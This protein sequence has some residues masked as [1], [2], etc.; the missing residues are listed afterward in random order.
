M[1][2]RAVV[3][4]RAFHALAAGRALPVFG[5]FRESDEVLHSDGRL[6]VEQFAA[7]LPHGGIDDSGWAGG[8]RTCGLGRRLLGL[9]IRDG[10]TYEDRQKSKDSSTHQTCISFHRWIVIETIFTGSCGRSLRSSRG[11]RD[12]SCASL[13]AAAS[14]WPKIT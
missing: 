3:E 9:G 6:L 7:Q 10:A 2:T 4:R 8:N 13:T 12:A 5:S 1:K 14:H 11:W